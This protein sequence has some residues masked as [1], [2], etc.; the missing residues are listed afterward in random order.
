MLT[1]TTWK[2]GPPSLACSLSS[3]GIS[4]RQGTHQVAHRFSSTVRP[5][6]SARVL[7]GR[8]PALEGDVGQ[9]A[10]RRAGLERRHLAVDQGIEAAAVAALAAQAPRV[11][12]PACPIAI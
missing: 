9:R 8:R 10:G 7:G 2:S 5:R 11:A 1:A 12:L 3:A 4:L 6:K